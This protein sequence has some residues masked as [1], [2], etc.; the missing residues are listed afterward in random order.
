MAYKKGKAYFSAH[1]KVYSNMVGKVGWQG[2]KEAEHIVRKLRNQKTVNA[3]VQFPLYLKKNRAS[4]YGMILFTFWVDLSMCI[5][6][7]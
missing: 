3:L 2:C 1:L 6:P 4:S 7:I 5:N